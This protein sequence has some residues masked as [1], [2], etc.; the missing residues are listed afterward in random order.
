MNASM[1]T[2]LGSAVR[3]LFAREQRLRCLSIA[4]LVAVV[5]VYMILEIYGYRYRVSDEGIYFYLAKRLTEGAVPYR[6]FFFAHPPG[7]ILVLALAQLFPFGSDVMKFKMVAPLCAI[8]VGVLLFVATPRLLGIRG[9]TRE[10]VGLAAACC[11]LLSEFVL[12]FSATDSGV[13]EGAVFLLAAVVFASSQRPVGAGLAVALSLMTMQQYAPLAL[14]LGLAISIGHGLAAGRRYFLTAA[15]SL[16]GSHLVLVAVAGP[17]FLRQVYAYHWGKHENPGNVRLALLMFA[18]QAAWPLAAAL[19]GGVAMVMRGGRF[20]FLACAAAAAVAVHLVAVLTRPDAFPY[21]FIPMMIPVA[22]LAGG[23]LAVF[24]TAAPKEST[25]SV[26]SGESRNWGGRLEMA[27]ASAGV[28]LFSCGFIHWAFKPAVNLRGLYAGKQWV[29][30]PLMGQMNRLV[31]KTLWSEAAAYP[32][33]AVSRYLRFATMELST[34]PQIAEFA[35]TYRRETPAAALIGDPQVVPIVALMSGVPVASDAADMNYQRFL[36]DGAAAAQV[37]DILS[38]ESA[39]L[40][41]LPEKREVFPRELTKYIQE[42]FTIVASFTSSR[43]E[44]HHIYE[45]PGARGLA[46][47]SAGAH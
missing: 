26:S 41:V 5:A 19:A 30:S 44:V 12:V 23:G 8:A 1:F 18:G 45:L 38:S 36:I 3:R 32:Q 20:R 4:G 35:R 29:D 22:L 24:T 37:R 31:R 27:L 17:D 46:S 47:S 14:V 10:L 39:L 16:L 33:W 34:I 40:V 25:V 28:F 7:H 11:F 42:R 15:L 6:D 2:S 43:H 9:R 13:M 21:Y